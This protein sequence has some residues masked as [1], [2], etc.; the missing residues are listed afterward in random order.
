MPDALT[1][2]L[3]GLCGLCASA[4]AG[5]C[6]AAW[7]YRDEARHAAILAR[8]D[9]ANARRSAEEAREQGQPPARDHD[10]PRPELRVYRG[11]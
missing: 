4:C 9:S 8:W 10:L 2:T 1:L 6:A 7:R 5:L 3:A 11:E